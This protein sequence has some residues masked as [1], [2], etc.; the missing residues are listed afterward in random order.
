MVEK[1]IETSPLKQ[2][3]PL[4]FNSKIQVQERKSI[5][6]TD[7]PSKSLLTGLAEIGNPFLESPGRRGR[8]H[9]R[10][11]F[12]GSQMMTRS[13]S[14]SMSRGTYLQWTTAP[15]TILAN[16]LMH[17]V[18]ETSKQ[19]K[20]KPLLL[21]TSLTL[22][23]VICTLAYVDQTKKL[24]AT[25]VK[26]LTPF[27]VL[28]ASGLKE[29]F[30]FG[31]FNFSLVQ[32]AAS[33]IVLLKSLGVKGFKKH[34]IQGT[35]HSY[36]LWAAIA[37]HVATYTAGSLAGSY[38]LYWIATKCRHNSFFTTNSRFRFWLKL[39]SKQFFMTAALPNFLLGLD[40]A[41]LVAG[42]AGFTKAQFWGGLVAGRAIFGIPI[43][44]A[45][46][47]FWADASVFEMIL[48]SLSTNIPSLKAPI[49]IV[50]KSAQFISQ[51]D[52]LAQALQC[53]HLLTLAY[54]GAC[55]IK[56][57]ANTRAYNRFRSTRR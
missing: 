1:Q 25:A 48:K 45:Y 55:V 56:A 20:N 47:S 33:S 51:S 11:T 44:L 52:M 49:Q 23:A 40:V 5:S 16:F 50:A 12:F 22:F 10:N 18:E 32:F 28:F 42:F 39:A 27:A 17:G 46:S 30:G 26:L 2:T 57:I 19:F 34:T 31:S 53:A 29:A 54:L 4:T 21:F 14:Q 6:K 36:G 13:R 41:G 43:R 15:H 3:V 38:V 24:F 9:F 35:S 7:S 8:S 37:A